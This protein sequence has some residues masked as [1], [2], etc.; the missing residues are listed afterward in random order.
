MAS[1]CEQLGIAHQ[2]AKERVNSKKRYK[3]SPIEVEK[4]E[5]REKYVLS[6]GKTSVE[7]TVRHY[8]KLR[9]LFDKQK[10][11][12]DNL[13]FNQIVF[14]L[15]ARYS[16]LQGGHHKTGG[17][18]ASLHERCFD[19]L[20]DE[21]E[22]NV[23]CFASPFNCNMDQYCSKFGDELDS[24]FGSI[25]SFFRFYPKHGCFEVRFYCVPH[26]HTN[27]IYIA[28]RIHRQI[29]LSLRNSS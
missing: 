28:T 18:Q 26:T 12:R 8:E 10:A 14:C 29:L 11:F 9:G 25:G 17:Y 15:L 19:V 20:R 22:C 6:C 2:A 21:F 27:F 23:E 1:I 24:Y 13:T 3:N 4:M 16:A 5:E 7:I